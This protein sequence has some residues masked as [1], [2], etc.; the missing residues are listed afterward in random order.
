MVDS[1][2]SVDDASSSSS[3]SSKPRMRLRNILI[4]VVMVS[5]LVL[6]LTLTQSGTIST[7]ASSSYRWTPPL[8]VTSTHS[9]QQAQPERIVPPG[10]EVCLQR[11]TNAQ[12]RHRRF[13]CPQL[14]A[15]TAY[16]EFWVTPCNNT[17][18]NNNNNK[19][20]AGCHETGPEAAK[21]VVEQQRVTSDQEFLS[22]MIDPAIAEQCQKDWSTLLLPEEWGN[23]QL[24]D[25]TARLC[26]SKP[27]LCQTGPH[28]DVDSTNCTYEDL[29][30]PPNSLAIAVGEHCRGQRE[31]HQEKQ[32]NNSTQKDWFTPLLQVIQQQLQQQQIDASTAPNEKPGP[33]DIVVH[34]RVG[35]VVD[36]SA[37]S[38]RELLHHKRQYDPIRGGFYVKPTAYYDKALTEQDLRSAGR[39]ILVASAHH[40]PRPG[41][42]TPAA[43]KSCYYVHSLR[44]YF[45]RRGATT[46]MLR[47]GGLPDDDVLFMSQ[48]ARFVPSGGTFSKTLG[49]LVHANGGTVLS[50]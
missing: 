43:V 14:D 7:L 38:V 36:M 3:S 23:Y 20:T 9:Q 29:H 40:G 6:V 28:H 12:R 8:P 2:A 48:S 50:G 13:V 30:L 11:I 45:L 19:L 21:V 5:I 44:Q 4:A 34:L 31:Q 10:Q 1:S 35:D 16:G 18:N 32:T 15:S 37:F 46:V 47:L 25:Q 39:I 41:W 26:G 27:M 22:Y 17:D 24:M 42:T 49:K 33:T